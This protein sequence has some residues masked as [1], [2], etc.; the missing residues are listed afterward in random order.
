MAYYSPITMNYERLLKFTVLV[1]LLS[2]TLVSGTYAKYTS[3]ATGSDTA[4]VAKYHVTFTGSDSVER[5][6]NGDSITNLSFELFDPAK[7]YDENGS[8]AYTVKADDLDVKNGTT[9]A[10]I[11][12]G[13]WGEA[14]FTLENKS[15]VTVKY[16]IGYTL[17]NTSSIP[18]EFRTKVGSAEWS[19]WGA[20]AANITADDS[21][22]RLEIP[23]ATP[24]GTEQVTILV[25][26][27]WAFDNS[28][29][30]AD[31]ALGVAAQTTAP[32]ATL[33]VAVTFTQ[34]D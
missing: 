26:W 12:P 7:I 30:P 22:T 15:E 8:S 10:L 9:D 2:L 4:K 20:S 21:A 23:A 6:I 17:T 29:D 3:T 34:V 32:S 25:Q 11:A 27:R 33:E 18:L 31:T 24:D 16:G 14:S 13:T 5:N 28:D 1:A 19:S